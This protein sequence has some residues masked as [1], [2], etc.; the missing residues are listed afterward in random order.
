MTLQSNRSRYRALLLLF[1]TRVSYS[2]WID[3]PTKY[4]LE[5]IVSPLNRLRR[6]QVTQVALQACQRDAARN[7]MQNNST[8]TKCTCETTSKG[9]VSVCMQDCLYCNAYN[10]TCGVNS[11]QSLYLPDGLITSVGGVFHYLSGLTDTVAIQE[12]NCTEQN[13]VVQF[14]T[15]CDAFVNGAKCNSCVFQKMSFRFS[16]S[17]GSA[18]QLREPCQR[19]YLRLVWTSECNRLCF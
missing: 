6:L 7:E 19:L 8:G 15:L 1:L 5:R 17:R 3:D 11:I 16:I 13:N 12:S 18:N 4:G 10:T 14:C 9:V 2:S